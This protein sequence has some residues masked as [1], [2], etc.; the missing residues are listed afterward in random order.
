[1]GRGSAE[2]GAAGAAEVAEDADAACGAH[3]A[4]NGAAQDS[5]EPGHADGEAGDFSKMADY[6]KSISD[7][8]VC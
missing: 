7:H 4:A 5:D 1:M 8:A 2:A 6:L 3:V